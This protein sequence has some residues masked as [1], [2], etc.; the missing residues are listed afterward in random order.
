MSTD[1][2]KNAKSARKSEAQSR[3]ET[4]APMRK[5]PTR[6]PYNPGLHKFVQG[7]QA[8]SEPLD[9]EA[10]AKGFL[11]WHQRGYVPHCDAPGITQFVTLR[12]VD[13]LPASKRSEWEHLLKMEITEAGAP[14]CSRLKPCGTSVIVQEPANEKLDRN[15]NA[16]SRSQTGAP[17]RT[18][19]RERR[20]KLEAYLDRGLGSCWLGRPAIATIAEGALRFFDGQRYE[21]GAWVIMPN[22]LHVLVDVWDTPLSGMIKSWK[23]FVARESNKILGR[24]GAFWEREYLDTVVSDEAHWRRAVRY[25]VNNPVK[26]GLVSETKEWAWSSAR[27]R[28]DYGR[29]VYPEGQSRSQ[30]GAPGR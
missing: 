18:A 9:E 29:L 12:L 24:H 28:D 27:F 19:G 10:R 1:M 30:T 15:A 11:G 6:P 13:S 7:K 17:M 14:A 16:Q 8:W 20:R 22:H 4:G 21:L 25:I 3:S 5:R 26:A 23:A 2:D